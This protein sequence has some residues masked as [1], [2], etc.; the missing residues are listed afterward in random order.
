[1]ET[2][3]RWLS[4]ESLYDGQRTKKDVRKDVLLSAPDHSFERVQHI[5]DTTCGTA[6]RAFAKR[7]SIGSFSF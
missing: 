5:R 4:W 7:L 3:S 6:D 1:M 2:R